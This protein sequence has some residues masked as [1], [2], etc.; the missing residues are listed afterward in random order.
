[1]G[2]YFNEELITNK[3]GTSFIIDRVEKNSSLTETYVMAQYRK[4]S[5]VYFIKYNHEKEAQIF[6]GDCDSCGWN[7]TAAQYNDATWGDILYLGLH[8]GVVPDY[9][10]NN[11]SINSIDVIEGNAE[12]VNHI[13]WINNN[14]NVINDN[15]WTY[16]PSK[17]YDIIICD[18]WAMPDDITQ[19]NKTALVNNYNNHLKS[20]GKIIIPISGETIN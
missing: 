13:T 17:T 10:Y 20:G 5:D 7:V 14:I 9:I 15:P 11:K 19:D 6:V 8:L 4:K 16:T 2:V 1:M 12:L 18:L 3:D